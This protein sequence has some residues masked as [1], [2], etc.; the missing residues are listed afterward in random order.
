MALYIC[1]YSASKKSPRRASGGFF[2]DFAL[3]MIITAA[4]LVYFDIG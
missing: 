2:E 3:D 4:G 1:H